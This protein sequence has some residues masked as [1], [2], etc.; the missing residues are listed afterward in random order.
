[1]KFT[2]LTLAMMAAL[3]AS[4][5]FDAAAIEL[6]VDTTTEQ[7]YAKPG[8]GRVLMGSFEKTGSAP[9]A[10]SP[11]KTS[12]AT[13][14]KAIREDLAVKTQDL[15]E[16]TKEIKSLS[17]LAAVAAKPDA[18]KVSLKDGLKFESNDGNFTTEIHGRV[19]VDSQENVNQQLDKSFLTPGG[20]PAA[21]DNSV[22]LRRARL[23]MEGTIYK[24]ADYKLE[25]DFT[26]G[27]TIA[28]GIT[29]AWAR[30]NFSKPFSVKIGSFK[31]PLTLEDT[32]SDIQTPFIERSMAVNAFVDNLNI[33]KMGIGS[34]YSADR[35]LVATG[36]QTQGPGSFNSNT[37]FS[38]NAQNTQAAT[39]NT[40]WELNGRVAGTPW[41]TSPTQLLH[42]G[43]WGSYTSVNNNL[44]GNGAPNAT[45]P[46]GVSF[47]SALGSNMDRTQVLSTGNLSQS[48]TELATA[49]NRFGAETAVVLGPFSA[50]AEF[51]QTNVSGN[52]YSNNALTGYYGYMT[53]FLTGESRN[54]VTRTGAF[55]RVKPKT[56]FDMNG[57]TGAW[58]LLVG[59]D[60]LNLRSGDKIN[61]G[62]AE[63]G[64]L[65]VN[66]YFNPRIRLM[67]NYVHAFNINTTTA[68]LGGTLANGSQVAATQTTQSFNNAKLDM[69][70]SRV[71]LDW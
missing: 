10:N 8:P 56:N 4:A 48:A 71:Q 15:A 46:G 68:G 28:G 5:S 41:M 53:Y 43:G 2:K 1:M 9:T 38:Q 61:G 17:E 16:K 62:A 21:L 59:F 50:Q 54:Y 55:D 32:T 45:I 29:D 49:Y 31:E 39:G 58:E 23:G 27:T 47:G 30:Y 33:F 57:G 37:A 22:G 42:V 6:Y 63:L 51:L 36:L 24:N 35:W 65:G 25:Y 60:E 26:R 64:K 40:Q 7:I 3:T 18:V 52:G 20:T 66:W 12:T 67:T 69:I 11:T 44:N 19:Q 70:E 14:L 13:E 34:T